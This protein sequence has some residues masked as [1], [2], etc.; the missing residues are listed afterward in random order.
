MK[1]LS[2]LLLCVILISVT[3]HNV[4]A[5]NNDTVGEVKQLVDGIINYKL[6]TSSSSSL[7]EW[8]DITLSA[9]PASGNEWYAFTLSQYV[10]CDTSTYETALLEYLSE[11]K[12]YSPASGLKFA[13]CLASFGSCD[14]YILSSIDEYTEKGGI[15]SLIFGLHLL[16]NGYI[17][18]KYTADG[19]AEKLFS[20][21]CSDGGWSLDGKK[22]DVDVTSMALQALPPHKDLD[23]AEEKIE[24]ALAFLSAAQLDNGTY[25]SY[26]TENPE[27]IAQVI[28]A[29]SSLGIDCRYDERFIK[30][31]NTLFDAMCLFRLDDGSFCHTL[32]QKTSENATVQAFYS[33]VSYLRMKEGREGLYILDNANTAI[34]VDKITENDD[35]DE[36]TVPTGGEKKAINY[37]H[38]AYIIASVLCVI[39]CLWFFLIKKRNIK[40]Y[41]AVVLVWGCIVCI[42]YFTDVHLPGNYYGTSDIS[43]GE[44]IGHVSLCIRCDTVSDKGKAHIPSDGVMLEYTEFDL[45]KGDTVYDVLIRAAKSRSLRLDIRGS[46]ESAYVSGINSLYEFDFGDLSGWMYRVNGVT[47]NVACGQYALTDG[48]NIEWLYTVQLGRDIE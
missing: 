37:K 7:Q 8:I 39:V 26:G 44:V 31:G 10:D 13:L 25:K 29:L 34:A 20:M 21:Q 4:F 16:N 30:N 47:P 23:G 22:G 42:V 17:S 48:D 6:S 43:T 1:K 11:N 3:P 41:I 40:N 24:K 27:S 15:M 38:L 35:T 18:D 2:A 9:S 33:S 19:T 14:G 45:I 5:E 36:P 46:E 12:A 32:G 28:T